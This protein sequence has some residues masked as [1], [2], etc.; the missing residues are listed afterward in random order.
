MQANDIAAFF[1]LFDCRW[2]MRC[3]LISMS[4]VSPIFCR[5]SWTL[6]SPKSR[7][8]AA[9]AARTYAALKVLETAIRRMS[10]GSRPARRAA[11]SI[12]DLTD[13]RLE[14][15]ASTVDTAAT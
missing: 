1:A 9:H 14:A 3:H 13:W 4:D 11:A 8:P 15:T 2:P 10:E 7:W 5:A 6:F 12:R